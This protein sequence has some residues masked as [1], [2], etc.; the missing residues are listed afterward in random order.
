MYKEVWF[1][2]LF[3]VFFQ[4]WLDWGY[5]TI[6]LWLFHFKNEMHTSSLIF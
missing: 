2:C 4:S 3:R 6:I 5:S 1:F